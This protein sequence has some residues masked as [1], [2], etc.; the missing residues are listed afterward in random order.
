MPNE[1][2]RRWRDQERDRRRRRDAEILGQLG[3]VDEPTAES[4]KRVGHPDEAGGGYEP[5]NAYWYDE[6]RGITTLVETEAQLRLFLKQQ[7]YT[8]REFLQ[9]PQAQAA[10]EA[11]RFDWLEDVYARAGL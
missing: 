4:Q 5:W 8:L 9:L 10:R 7:G 1:S 2:V 3:G 11:N 6:E